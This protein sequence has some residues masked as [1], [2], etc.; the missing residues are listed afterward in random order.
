MADWGMASVG[1]AGAGALKAFLTRTEE[2][3]VEVSPQRNRRAGAMCV[4]RGNEQANPDVRG[5]RLKP[6]AV[7]TLLA[8]RPA[9][10][11]GWRHVASKRRRLEPVRPDVGDS[12]DRNF[13]DP[14][15]I[16]RI[17]H[18]TP[19][20]G[21]RRVGPELYPED[22]N[23]TLPTRRIS[24]SGLFHPRRCETHQYRSSLLRLLHDATRHIIALFFIDTKAGTGFTGE[25]RCECLAAL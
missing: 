20:H 7:P 12:L 8:K 14:V 17:G 21:G 24:P 13:D 15:A 16:R 6:A 22:L 5:N 2:D 18:V 11:E 4:R 10:L 25:T 23:R 3:S 1:K 19:G 9:A